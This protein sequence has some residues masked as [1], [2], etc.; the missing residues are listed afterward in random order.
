LFLQPKVKLSAKGFCYYRNNIF[1]EYA[2]TA[3]KVA[4]CNATSKVRAPSSIPNI[5]ETE[6]DAGAAYR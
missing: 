1:P 6:P 5:F 4:R 2:N 3:I